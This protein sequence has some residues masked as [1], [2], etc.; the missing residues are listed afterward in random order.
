MLSNEHEPVNLGNPVELSVLKFAD[1]IIKLTK[2]KSGKEFRPLPVDD[3]KLRRPDI[4]KAKDVLD[5]K[6]VVGLEEG[7]K[8]TISWFEKHP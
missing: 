6:P 1:A 5:W 8:N 7:L 3:P 4:S 2:S